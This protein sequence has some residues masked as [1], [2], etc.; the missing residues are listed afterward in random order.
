METTT[1][2]LKRMHYVTDDG[3]EMLSP[4]P[5]S[6]EGL[7]LR[8]DDRFPRASKIVKNTA[9]IVL[10]ISLILGLPQLVA[11]VSQIPFIA[12]KFGTFESPIVL[13]NWLNII[14]PVAAGLAALERAITL[15]YHWLIDMDTWWED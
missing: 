10:L 3:E 13:P 5:N 4:H 2:G 15:R 12:E 6:L 8:L 7:R 9:I 14:L 1:Y 11:L